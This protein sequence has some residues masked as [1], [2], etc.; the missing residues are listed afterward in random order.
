LTGLGDISLSQLYRVKDKAVII[1]SF[2]ATQIR[3]KKD[4]GKSV[5]GIKG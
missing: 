5:K 3:V 4:G 2:G 1:D